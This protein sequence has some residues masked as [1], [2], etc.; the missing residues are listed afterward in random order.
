MTSDEVITDSTVVF[1]S[2][3]GAT[4]H[5]TNRYWTFYSNLY[6][7]PRRAVKGPESHVLPVHQVSIKAIKPMVLQSWMGGSGMVNVT[8]IGSGG[9]DAGNP[10]FI[11]GSLVP[12]VSEPVWVEQSIDAFNAFTDQFPEE[13]S[14]GN[15]LLELDDLAKVIPKVLGVLSKLKKAGVFRRDLTRKYRTTAAKTV[16]KDLSPLSPSAIGDHFLD[17]SFNW[18]PLVGDLKAI[19]GMCASITSRID[20]LKRTRGIPTK[21]GFSRE[22]QPAFPLSYSID[23]G[24]GGFITEIVLRDY[25]STYRAGAYLLQTM[26]HLDDF[27]GLLRAFMGKTGLNNP[28]K[29]A[30]NAIPFSFILDWIVPVSSYLARFKIQGADSPWSLLDLTCSIKQSCRIEVVQKDRVLGTSSLIAVYDFKRYT[31][32]VELPVSLRGLPPLHTL[33]TKQLALVLAMST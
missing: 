22:I 8:T 15:F 3:G 11:F 6:D 30:W 13:M 29:V 26:T 16:I 23:T 27:Y 18:A 21:V 25:K 28:L 12:P 14:L 33:T 31:R 2:G 4:G 10:A 5:M 7:F 20:F 24:P 17:Y 1:A 9:L 32:L 19:F